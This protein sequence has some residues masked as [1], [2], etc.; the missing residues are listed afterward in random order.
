MFNLLGWTFQAAMNLLLK[1]VSIRVKSTRPGQAQVGDGPVVVLGAGQAR[2][3]RRRTGRTSHASARLD[4]KSC[5]S[6]VC[7]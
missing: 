2:A 3:G 6:G 7:T 4:L 5:R 1:W